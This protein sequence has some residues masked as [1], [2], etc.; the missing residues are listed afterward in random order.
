MELGIRVVSAEHKQQTQMEIKCHL[1]VKRHEIF[2]RCDCVADND[3]FGGTKEHS[4][5]VHQDHTGEVIKIKL[6]RSDRQLHVPAQR[7]EEVKE[8][9]TQNAVV[10]FRKNEGQKTPDLTLQNERLVKAQKGIEHIATVDHTHNRNQRRAQCNIQHQIGNTLVTML[11]TEAIEG[12]TQI[13]QANHLLIKLQI[14]YH[15]LAEK[16]IKEL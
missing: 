16:S 11:K 8:H 4:E 10:S 7:I 12:S 9:K 15:Y 1:G 13:F 3:R 6:Q 5:N 2:W 14:S